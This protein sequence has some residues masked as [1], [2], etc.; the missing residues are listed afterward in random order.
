MRAVL[1]LVVAMLGAGGGRAADELWVSIREPAD[2]AMLV[3]EVEVVVEVVAVGEVAEVE[4]LLDGRLVGILTSPPYRLPI[5]L[6]ADNTEHRSADLVLEPV[7][8]HASKDQLI[9][10]RFAAGDVVN[11]DANCI[12][13]A[14]LCINAGDILLRHHHHNR[15]FQLTECDPLAVIVAR[16]A[17]RLELHIKY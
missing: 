4:F 2:E 16:A 12:C 5:D 17:E 6:G 1:L 15:A 9:L 13:I 7:D 3:G 11:G 14:V 8:D 10:V